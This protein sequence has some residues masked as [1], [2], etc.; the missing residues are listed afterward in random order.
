MYTNEYKEMRCVTMK[1][2]YLL[3]TTLALV[4]P[5]TAKASLA[6]GND[7]YVA[8]NYGLGIANKFD[9]DE[10]LAVRRPK[11]SQIFGLAAGY[12]F[13][14][15]I[16]GE[17]AFNRFHK[18]EY[19]NANSYDDKNNKVYND[20]TQKISANTLFAN[21]YY[22]INK[23]KQFTPYV[24][25]GLGVSRN[26]VGDFEALAQVKGGKK[27]EETYFDAKFHTTIAWNIG[28]GL[29]YKASNKVTLD[30]ISYKYYNLGVVATK[31]D[32]KERRFK[33]KL[34]VHSI[35]AGIRINLN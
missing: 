22:D 7:A 9:Y 34:R 32:A 3:I 19:K 10:D 33:S 18:F 12:K 25:I 4:I 2:K 35:N 14:D 15:N 20:Y 24:N 8:L 1:N 6:A 23:F 17:L 29:S 21:I 5:I 13:N 31:E 30:L 11:N 26:Q 27:S 16:R 28:A